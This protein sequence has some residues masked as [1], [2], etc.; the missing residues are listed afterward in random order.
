MTLRRGQAMEPMG[1]N[2]AELEGFLSARGIDLD[3]GPA[4]V[5]LARESED[6]PTTLLREALLFP[7]LPCLLSD[8]SDLGSALAAA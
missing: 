4:C 2:F 5:I 1:N 7:S 6:V 8:A 3:H